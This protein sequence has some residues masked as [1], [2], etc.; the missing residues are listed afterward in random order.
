MSKTKP[1]AAKRPAPKP[2]AKKSPDRPLGLGPAAAEAKP[3]DAKP[4]E[5]AD[6]PVLRQNAPAPIC[7]YHKVPCASNRSDPFFTRYYCPEADCSYSQKV[8]RPRAR[9]VQ[10]GEDFSAR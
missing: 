1:N 4:A 7:P 3:E 9:P 5:K 6:G 10:D 8:P 2:P